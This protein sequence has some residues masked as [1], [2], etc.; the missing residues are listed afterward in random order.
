MVKIACIDMGCGGATKKSLEQGL[1]TIFRLS[2]NVV[3]RN[4]DH[5]CCPVC[6]GEVSIESE[7]TT[8]LYK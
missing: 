6:G 2:S 1:G 3:M 8:D 4:A 5:L 7:V